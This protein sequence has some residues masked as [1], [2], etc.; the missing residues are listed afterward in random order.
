MAEPIS[1]GRAEIKLPGDNWQSFALVEEV[2]KFDGDRSGKIT[3]E[4]K[5]FIKKSSSNAVETIVVISGSVG[6]LGGSGK[7]QYTPSCSSDKYWY[8]NGNEGFNRPFVECWGVLKGQPIAPDV[9]KGLVPELAPL[10]SKEDL[11]IPD[12]TYALFSTYRNERGTFLTVKMFIASGFSV[13]NAT[14]VESMSEGVDVKIMQYGIQLSSAVRAS[15]NSWSG[16]LAIPGL[17]FVDQ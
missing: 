10:L 5:V 2:S 9:L 13:P 17:R 14:A 11:R 4:R 3:S 8:R 12:E 7:L 15:V 6:G 16:Q 1:V